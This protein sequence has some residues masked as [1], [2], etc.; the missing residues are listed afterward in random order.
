VTVRYKERLVYK[1]G[2]SDARFHNLGAMPLLFWRTIQEAKALPL[3]E[4]DLGRSD[5]EDQGLIAFKD[6]LG[7]SSSTLSCYRHPPN[8]GVISALRGGRLV[9][10]L[11][12]HLPLSLLRAVGSILYRHIG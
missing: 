6:H 2:A 4:L 5:W 8:S 10:R 12:T 3:C 9:A 11:C 7:A 1:Y